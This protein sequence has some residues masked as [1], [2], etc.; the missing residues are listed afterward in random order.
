MFFILGNRQPVMASLIRRRLKR[1]SRQRKNV[2]T[3]KEK[4]ATGVVFTKRVRT[5]CKRRILLLAETEGLATA[6][7]AGRKIRGQAVKSE[8]LNQDD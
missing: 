4:P 8:A 6:P 2:L 3:G 7:T 5:S 1:G